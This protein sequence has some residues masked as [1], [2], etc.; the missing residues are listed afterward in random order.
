M[1]E[2]QY[3]MTTKEEVSMSQGALMG[4]ITNKRC[5]VVLQRYVEAPERS[6]NVKRS[7]EEDKSVRRDTQRHAD[8]GNRVRLLCP[9]SIFRNVLFWNLAC[10]FSQN[11]SKESIRMMTSLIQP[12]LRSL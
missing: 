12:R 7:F 2:L 4:A 8:Q 10:M 6:R 3:R 5:R 1:A 11:Y 9:L